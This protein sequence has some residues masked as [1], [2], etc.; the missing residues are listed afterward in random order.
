MGKFII[1]DWET[2]EQIKMSIV[3]ISEKIRQ[4]FNQLKTIQKILFPTNGKKR[5]T[6]FNSKKM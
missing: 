5:P 2:N 3:N 1:H 4:E 6:F